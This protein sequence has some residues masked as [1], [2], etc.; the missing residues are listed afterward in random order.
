MPFLSFSL[1][2]R[3]ISRIIHSIVL[4][5]SLVGLLVPQSSAHAAASLTVSPITWNVVGLD[6]N[7]V[8]VGPNN[9][10]VG[11]RVCNTGDAP[12]TNVQADFVWDSANALINLRAGSLDPIS[13]A[14]LSN[15]SPNNCYDFYFEVEITRNA[16]AY[17]TTRRYHI[18]VT[19][20]GG[21]SLSTTTPRE[22]YV[23]HLVSQSRN[24]TLDVKLDG[25]SIAPGGTMAMVI[26]QTYT[27][28]LVAKT[29][30]NGYEQIE[31]FI[32]FP[33]TIFQVLSVD[34]TYSADSSPNVDNPSDMLYGDGCI[35]VNDPNSPNYRS[36]VSTGK[37]GGDITVDYV[38][39][40]IGGAGTSSILNTLIYDFS[41]SSYHYNSDYAVGGRIAVIVD[42]T[43]VDISKN[44][45]PD[46]TNEGGISKLTFT[47]TNSNAAAVSGVSFDDIFPTTPGAMVV[48]NPPGASTAGCG[49][50]TF[51]PT[52]GAAS[53]S[54]SNGTIAAN[55]TCTV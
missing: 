1:K 25:T 36:C 52:A 23:D 39:R 42:P 28:T 32:N 33:N 14:S 21:I 4:A 15:I 27:I 46:P 5:S 9:F 45:N 20:D 55:G 35:W 6:S 30:T 8:S 7:N 12:A 49:T 2:Y 26:G 37:A 50:P 40:I 53:I 47:L 22:I 43:L 41:G 48:A 19:A 24:S 11:V 44:F 29:A 10:P 16:A 13:L 34:T 51:A 54:F 3:G 18:A 17:D 38:V 31:S